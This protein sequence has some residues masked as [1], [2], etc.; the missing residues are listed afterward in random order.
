MLAQNTLQKAH[1]ECPPA[2]HLDLIREHPHR[3]DDEG[4]RVR[5]AAQ[6]RL[7]VGAAMPLSSDAAANGAEERQ[8]NVGFVG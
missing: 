8:T 3:P 2:E 4:G 6:Q 5:P 7:V 1:S